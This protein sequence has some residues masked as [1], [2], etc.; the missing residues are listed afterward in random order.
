MLFDLSRP[1]LRA[2]RRQLG[3][4]P[5]AYVEGAAE[6]LLPFRSRTFGAV[7]LVGLFGFFGKDS[8]TVLRE[9]HRVLLPGG[10]VIVEGQNLPQATV[11]LAPPNPE[12]FRAIFRDPERS[13]LNAILRNEV[14]PY[15]P[16]HGA[17]YEFKFWRSEGLAS[18]LKDAGFIV[19]DRMAVAPLLG[20]QPNVLRAFQKDRRAWSNLLRFEEAVGR[21][22]TLVDGG[23]VGLVAGHRRGG[24]A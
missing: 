13:Y 15:D 16:P 6:G 23:L 11:V 3:G 17:R 18:A 4:G 1:M 8:R 14:Q 19:T 24:R 21:W 2:A 12:G 9:A 22:P 5:R 20:A 10:V 7:I